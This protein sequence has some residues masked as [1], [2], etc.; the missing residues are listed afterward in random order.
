MQRKGVAPNSKSLRK[1]TQSAQPS[2]TLNFQPMLPASY[3]LQLGYAMSTIRD[4]HGQVLNHGR[5][6]SVARPYQCLLRPYFVLVSVCQ[7]LLVFVKVLFWALCSIFEC[8]AWPI[9]GFSGVEHGLFSI[10]GCRT[11]PIFDLGMSNMTYF[12]FSDVEHGR[13][14]VFGCRT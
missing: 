14:T 11:W 7:R 9:F 12:R 2:T 13:F 3:W 6:Q 5:W 10:F 1:S 8:R 4:F